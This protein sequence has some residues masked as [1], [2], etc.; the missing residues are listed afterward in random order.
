M[1]RELLLLGLLRQQEMHGYRLHE[2]INRGM[3]FC[4]DL[5]KPT[6]YFLLDKMAEAGWITQEETQTGNRPTRRVYRLTKKGEAEFQRLLRE[7]LNSHA[8]ARFTGDIGLA[9]L[10][11]LEPNE[12]LELLVQRRAALADALA[13]AEAVPE[14]EGTLQLVV[15]HQA[16]HLATELEWLDEV[17]ARL[18]LKKKTR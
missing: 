1:D 12:A 16:R 4:T 14:H 2:F 8:P 11:A 5:K 18:K 17:V 7:N 3:A 15:E 13:S 10:D 9:F 6:A